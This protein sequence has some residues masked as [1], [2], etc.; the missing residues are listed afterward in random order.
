MPPQ[1]D[2]HILFQQL[3]A[4]VLI[5]TYNN[6]GTLA[7]VIDSVLEYTDQVIVVNDGATDNTKEILNR[8]PDIHIVNNK[9]NRGKGFALRTGIKE[10]ARLGYDYA[11]SID[12][13]GQ[14][15]AYDLPK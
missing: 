6:A 12:S 4:C 2:S 9:R 10:A 11:V 5:P 7:Q 1:P 15:F 14:H 3:K 8:Y 13:D